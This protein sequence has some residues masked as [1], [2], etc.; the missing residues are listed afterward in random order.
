MLDLGRYGSREVMDLQLFNYLTKAPIMTMDYATSSQTENTAETVYARGGRGNPRRIAWHGDKETIV[1]VET[2]IFTMQHLALLAGENIV[3]GANEIYKSEVLTVEN[4]GTGTKII[5]LSKIPVGTVDDVAV[6][7]YKNGI[8]GQSQT[9]ETIS[10]K[11][12]QLAS[13]STAN[14]GDEVQVYYRWN[15]T[16]THKL[17]F[18][19]KGF[20]PYI[21]MVGDTVYSD[22]NSGEVVS[23]Q[24]KY[25]R[26]KLQPNFTITSAPSGDPSTLSLVFDVFPVKIN[27]VD[28]LYD[29]TIYE[30]E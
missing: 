16:N 23:A 17:S 3:S 4:G 11:E 5:N 30:D 7:V 18:T 6:F 20:P 13:T 28:T 1:T 29:M 9:V 10:N 2:Q 8:L 24:L 12:L 27:G 21:F 19:A 15:A 25:Y 26:A 14:I 22:E